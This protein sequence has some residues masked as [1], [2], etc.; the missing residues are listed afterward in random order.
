MG[1]ADVRSRR[2]ERRCS[3]ADAKLVEVFAL[4]GVRRNFTWPAA[5]HLGRLKESSTRQRAQQLGTGRAPRWSSTGW[6]AL[7][8]M[9]PAK[10]PRAG[11]RKVGF[12]VYDYAAQQGRVGWRT[13]CRWRAARRRPD[14]PLF[15]RGDVV[16]GGDGWKV[17][18][19]DD[20]R[21]NRNA[22]PPPGSRSSSRN[23]L[24]SAAS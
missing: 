13:A 19:R 17:G 5:V 8:D 4:R 21:L 16:T 18:P 2:C 1:A 7:C 24:C 15:A 14:R 9:E 10:P 3:S 22:N 23:R 6:D 12:D 20:S 11:S